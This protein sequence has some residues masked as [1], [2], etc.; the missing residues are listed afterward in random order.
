MKPQHFFLAIFSIFLISCNLDVPSFVDVFKGE[1]NQQDE[2]NEQSDT[3]ITLSSLEMTS[4]PDCTEYYLIQNT[5]YCAD[6][7]K[8]VQT[9]CFDGIEIF[10]N[11]S[12]YSRQKEDIND[13]QISTVEKKSGLQNVVISK[14][15][16]SVAFTILIKQK[17]NGFEFVS[18][19][20]K[21]ETLKKDV[22]QG[23]LSTLENLSVDSVQI[24]PYLISTTEILYKQWYEVLS[25]AIS[26][27]RGE[28]KY[29]FLNVGQEGSSGVTGQVWQGT[30]QP[31]V[32]VSLCD[33]RVWCNA[34]SEMYG[35]NPV[36]VNS[37]NDEI[38]RDSTKASTIEK[39]K[40]LYSNNGYRLPTIYEYEFALRCGS[41]AK[42]VFLGT[43]VLTPNF[44]KDIYSYDYSGT[45]DKKELSSYCNYNSE[46]TVPCA[47]LKSNRAGI[48]DLLGN[49]AEWTD[50]QSGKYFYLFGGSYFDSSCNINTFVELPCNVQNTTIGFRV[51]RL[52]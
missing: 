27:E 1:Q 34:A 46:N 22:L 35:L 14:E 20:N 21:T 39:C 40:T 23:G 13:L 37:E 43:E 16:K 8:V 12:D 42:N 18:P 9:I 49:V 33:V 38:L 7:Q 48:Y 52:M 17:E 36:Y 50:I 29:T 6:T 28:N 2:S 5:L 11:Y 41:F 4:L 15:N 45:N 3:K 47:S 51:A 44:E 31:V 24:N 26:D 10:S 30:N 25:W 19:L 32:A